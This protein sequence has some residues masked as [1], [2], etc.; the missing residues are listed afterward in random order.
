MER[1]IIKHSS[2]SKANQVEE[3]PLHHYKE[4][5]LGRDDSSTV[6]YD[7]DRDDLVGRQHARITC[8]PND[9]TV[10]FVEDLKSRNGTFLNKQRLAGIQ[11]LHPGDSVQ[12]GPGGPE[13]TFDIEPRPFNST[14]ATRIVEIA[15]ASP[16]TRVVSAAGNSGSTVPDSILTA[17]AAKTSVGKATVERMISHTVTETKKSEGRKFATI[18]GAAAIAVLILFGIVVGGGYWYTARKEAE[19]KAQMAKQD[20]EAGRRAEQMENESKS[21]KEQ[22]ANDKASAPLAAAQISDNFGKAVVLIQGSWQL[23]NKESKSQIYHQFIQNSREALSAIFKENFG[24]GAIVPNGPPTLPVYVQTAEGHEPYLTDKPSQLSEPMG[25]NT[26]TCSGFIVTSDGFILT[27]RHCSSPWK[28][29]YSFPQ[30]YPPG[31][32]IGTDGKIAGLVNAPTN[33]IPDNTKGGNRQYQGS[34]DGNQ[35]LSVTLPGTD[36]PIAAQSVQDSP[37]HDV[38]MI[39]ISVPGNLPKVELNDNYETIKKGEGLVIMGYPGNAP[40]VYTAIK[41]QNMLNTEVKGVIIPDPTVTVTAVGN[42]VRNSNPNDQAN[43]RFSNDGD[44]FRYAGGLTF[45][46]NSGGP[47]FDM[48]GKVI[49]IHFA[50]DSGQLAG[51]FS[52]WAVPIRYGMKL[53]PGGAAN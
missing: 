15:K 2:G 50:G 7:T 35:K 43:V 19:Q 26:Y 6:K 41:S 48:N 8:D 22:I 14:K 24:K 29:Q 33:W 44:S 12:L 20:E 25:S 36:S 37:S 30:N 13:F 31:I 28:A 18:G 11:K 10:F 40:V 49:G 4:L 51:N 5:I 34:F 46:G 17:P 3:F 47:V 38:G 53:F 21:L 42:I 32:L 16:E 39:K 9:S 45:G 52:G 27:N 1:M 23:V